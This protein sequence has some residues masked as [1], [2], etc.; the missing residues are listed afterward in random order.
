MTGTELT[1]KGLIG[2][3]ATNHVAANLLM[4]FVIGMGIWAA[5]M[6]KK[7]TMPE[8]R[9]DVV[10]VTVPYLG[11][12]PEEVDESVVVKIEEAIKNIQGIKE[13]RS[14]AADGFGQVRIEVQDGFDLGDL[15]DEAQVPA[16]GWRP[17]ALRHRDDVAADANRADRHR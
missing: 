5:I 15:T 10:T 1:P 7:E 11:G 2:W 17:A 8:F 9:F 6:V 14:T 13:I 4:F 3:F 16:A 12:A